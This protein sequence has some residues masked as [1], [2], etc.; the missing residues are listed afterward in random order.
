MTFHGSMPALDSS[1]VPG[2][3]S[4]E[5]LTMLLRDTLRFHAG[6]D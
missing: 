4:R 2:T 6:D 3:L 1:G 5:V